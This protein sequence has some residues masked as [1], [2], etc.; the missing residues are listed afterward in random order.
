MSNEITVQSV[1]G[2]RANGDS[3]VEVKPVPGAA[4]PLPISP[5]VP[6]PIPNPSLR[7]D[8]ALGLVV[9][10][11]RNESSDS[12]TTSIP[13]RRQLEAYQRWDMTHFGP[14]PAGRHRQA[15]PP[16]APVPHVAVPA[17]HVAAPPAPKGRAK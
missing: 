4:A 1:A 17:P 3:A 10:E 14:S 6:T 5:A 2:V 12:I 13:S 7:L 11:F 8:P 16:T 9:I 15:A